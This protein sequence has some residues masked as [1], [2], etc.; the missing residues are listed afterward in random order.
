MQ[1]NPWRILILGTLISLLIA[2]CGSSAAKPMSDLKLTRES[3]LQSRDEG[4]AGQGR[5][6]LPLRHRQPRS[7]Q[8]NPFYCG[9]I[10]QQHESNYNCYVAED[11]GPGSVLDFDDH[12][13]CD[14]CVNI[15]QDVM[16][17]Q[18][19]GKSVN[20]MR[21]VINQRYGNFGP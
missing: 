2:A 10:A 16:T 7:A 6:R 14:I 12:P 3:R 9:C 18:Q 8:A 5:R 13:R 17:M 15:T 4:P 20:A 19:E 11:G 1:Q 21:R